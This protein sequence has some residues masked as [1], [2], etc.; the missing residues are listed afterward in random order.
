M[1]TDDKGRP[2]SYKSQARF[3]GHDGRVRPVSAYG[4]N[5]TAAERALLKKLQD[6]SKTSQSG[7]LTAMHKISHLLDLWEKRFEGLVADG[8]RSPTSLD[9]YR[10]AIKNHIRPALGEVRIGEANTP[11]ID[12]VIS[13]IKTAAGAPTAKM[14]ACWKDASPARRS[15]VSAPSRPRSLGCGPS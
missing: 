5:K 15:G 1:K 7:E 4:K 13:K 12:T 8:K 2:I 6:R 10:R 14:V 11:R 3:R 9:T